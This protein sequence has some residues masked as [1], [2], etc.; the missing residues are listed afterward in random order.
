MV[1]PMLDGSPVDA[2]QIPNLLFLQLVPD[3]QSFACYFPRL[4]GDVTVPLENGVARS[5]S[6]GKPNNIE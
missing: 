1:L 4:H 5:E 6:E 2:A 3:R